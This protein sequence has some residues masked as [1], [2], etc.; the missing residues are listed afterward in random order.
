M[1]EIK[2]KHGSVSV[3]LFELAS[4]CLLKRLKMLLLIPD[5]TPRRAGPVYLLEILV[6]SLGEMLMFDFDHIKKNKA[7]LNY[8][9]PKFRSGF[10]V[11]VSGRS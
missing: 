11:F 4:K 9:C 7:I 2:I 8:Q 6:H 5:A 1:T 3:M 10:A